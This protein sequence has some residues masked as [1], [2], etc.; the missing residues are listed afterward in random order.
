VVW[1]LKQAIPGTGLNRATP[2]TYE[3]LSNGR[4]VA[5]RCHKELAELYRKRLQG[6]DWLQ[7]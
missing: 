1:V 2:I 5:K 7:A 3:A 6:R 4:A